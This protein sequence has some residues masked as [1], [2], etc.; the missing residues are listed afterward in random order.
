MP[1]PA[2]QNRMT[3]W[4]LFVLFLPFAYLLSF[5]AVVWIIRNQ[6]PMFLCEQVEEYYLSFYFPI[7]WLCE[8]Y[9]WFDAL[10]VW[11]VYLLPD[12]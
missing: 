5:G 10:M 11:Y 12:L 3:H 1:V 2:K 9:D 6:Y 7:Y 4:L 8:K